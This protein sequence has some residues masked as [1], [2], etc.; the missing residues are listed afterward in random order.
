MATGDATGG[1]P[2]PAAGTVTPDGVS[3]VHRAGGLETARRRPA[4]ENPLVEADNR[5]QE[6]GGRAHERRSANNASAS[7]RTARSSVHDRRAASGPAD[8]RYEPG[9]RGASA[10]AARR[11]RRRRLRSTAPPTRR[12]TA[13]ATRARSPSDPAP[14]TAGT[15]G[16]AGTQLADRG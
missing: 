4:G 3:A 11:R 6:A 9:A 13:K 7:P 1:E 14:A 2:H 10:S 8:T 12:P 5:D 15:A 16:S